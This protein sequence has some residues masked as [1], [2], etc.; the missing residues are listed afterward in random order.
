MSVAGAPA[1]VEPPPPPLPPPHAAT[2]AAA[3]TDTSD[4]TTRA[5]NAQ[6]NR[7]VA[8]KFLWAVPE[9]GLAKR[10][11]YLETPTLLLWGAADRLI[12]PAYARAFQNAIA[13]ARVELIDGAGHLPMV[14]QPDAFKAAVERFLA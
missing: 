10:L 4:D 11:P 7:A 13:D 9:R 14:E 8:A 5:L 2:A 3:A 12:D 6:Q 1:F